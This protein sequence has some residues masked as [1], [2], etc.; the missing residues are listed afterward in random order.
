MTIE[1]YIKEYANAKKK[2]ILNNELITADEC[3]KT[4][5]DCMSN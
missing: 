1:R 4:I 3:I 5:Y 2:T